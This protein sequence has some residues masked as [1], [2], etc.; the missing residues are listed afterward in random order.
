MTEHDS[1]NMKI[2]YLLESKKQLEKTYDVEL[3]KKDE[4][5]K[6]RLIKYLQ[7]FLTKFKR[8]KNKCCVHSFKVKISSPK[9]LGIPSHDFI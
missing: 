2:A 3:V 8:Q 4:Y 7:R 6:E 5:I 1:Q 9:R